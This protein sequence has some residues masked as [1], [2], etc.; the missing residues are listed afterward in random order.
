MPCPVPPSFL[1]VPPIL[2]TMPHAAPAPA[3]AAAES[4]VLCQ[5]VGTVPA[6]GVVA[7]AAETTEAPALDVAT[8]TEAIQEQEEDAEIGL[9]VNLA[10]EHTDLGVASG[11]TEGGPKMPKN[12]KT[13]KKKSVSVPDSFASIRNKISWFKQ[14]GST[15]NPMPSD[16]DLRVELTEYLE[17]LSQ[18]EFYQDYLSY[19]KGHMTK[20]SCL[21]IFRDPNICLVCANW[22][23]WS[24][25]R[26]K[27]LEDQ[28]AIQWVW[29]TSVLLRGRSKAYLIPYLNVYPGTNNKL[30]ELTLEQHALINH[31]L[32]CQNGIVLVIQRKTDYWRS[33]KSLAFSTGAA[34]VDGN[35]GQ[36]RGFV[37]NEVV[38]GHFWAFFCELE[39]LGEVR[40]TQQVRN[41]SGVANRN[42]EAEKTIYLPQSMTVRNVYGHYL[43]EL[44]F[45][46]T[47]Y[48]HKNYV[49]KWLG[50]GEQ[51]AYRTSQPFIV[52]GSESSGM[53]R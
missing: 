27:A 14:N 28:D 48:G 16:N 38:M 31:T 5:P 22:L 39:N 23:Q 1:P 37:R 53:S 41:I 3:V 46:I 33:I 12:K 34:K 10:G 36:K 44:G 18:P 43:D 52:F 47:T 25:K 7:A 4:Q 50:E 17:E 6:A 40:A 29:Y 2:P 35:V 9:S 20:C 49:V 26:Y 24:M 11:L 15:V 32:L 51:P 45:G 42:V 19:N 21:H 30:T 13:Y 8:A